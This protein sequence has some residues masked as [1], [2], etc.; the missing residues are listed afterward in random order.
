[1]GKL[2]WFKFFPGD[3]LKD[4]ELRMASMSSKGI[5][6]DVVCAMFEAKERGA[7]EATADQFCKLLGCPREEFDLFL[8][9]AKSLNFANVREM[10]AECP[11]RIRI[12]S[13]RMLRDENQRQD[14]ARQK[15]RQRGRGADAEESAECP[16]DVRAGVREKS[17]QCPPVESEIRSQKSEEY[18]KERSADAPVF[19]GFQEARSGQQQANGAGTEGGA[20]N[21]NPNTHLRGSSDL[22]KRKR[23]DYPPEFEQAFA[24]YP[25]RPA[26]D[27]KPAAYDAWRA[28]VGEG[29]PADDLIAGVGRY[30]A[31][32]KTSGTDF[33]K[34][35]STF[36]GNKE[37][38]KQPWAVTNGKGKASP[39]VPPTEDE[40][41]GGKNS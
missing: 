15:S 33:I 39:T 12:E 7:L 34:Q 14:W 11:E 4:H 31:Y 19:E 21:A 38:W 13:R 1:M 20:K 8:S 24:A 27:S 17:G 22:K 3:W 40:Y 41:Y 6:I 23:L 35:A 36:F 30:A 29:I 32:V 26:G 28:R 10:S 18:K 25:P 2:P 37:Y 9:E 16:E 5:W